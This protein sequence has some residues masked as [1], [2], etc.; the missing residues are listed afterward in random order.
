MGLRSFRCGNKKDGEGMVLLAFPSVHYALKAEKLVQE[1]GIKGGLR[2][3]PRQISTSCGLVLAVKEKD[4]AAVREL[5]ASRAFPVERF[6][7][8]VAG[9][10]R[11]EEEGGAG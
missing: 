1:A 10:W 9:G 6:Y 11:A 2:P 7:F 3:T 4:L 5:F 8:P